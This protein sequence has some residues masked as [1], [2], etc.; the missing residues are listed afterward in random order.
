[1]LKSRL[2]SRGVNGHNKEESD[3]PEVR[4]LSQSQ[5]TELLTLDIYWATPMAQVPHCF[6]PR[7]SRAGNLSSISGP[8]FPW[9]SPLRALFHERGCIYQVTETV[10]LV[11]HGKEREGSP[12]G[13]S[14]GIG[15]TLPFRV[16]PFLLLLALTRCW[17][18]KGMNGWL[19]LISLLLP[20]GNSD[21]YY[22]R[23]MSL[24]ANQIHFN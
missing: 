4:V 16:P 22:L 7:D 10:D 11:P 3:H 21:I 6:L 12:L 8:V 20:L 19:G 5:E 2:W 17:E 13:S 15:R 23:I 1:M 14:G 9:A 24:W 18:Q